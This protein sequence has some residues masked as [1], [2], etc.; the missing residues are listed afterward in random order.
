[1]GG[2]DLEYLG[3]L[4]APDFPTDEIETTHRISSRKLVIQRRREM[5]SRTR[6]EKA[7]EILDRLPVPGEHFHIISNGDFDYWNLV[8]IICELAGK[9]IIDAYFS[10][11]TMNRQCTL[12]MLDLL[13]EGR[14]ER[15]SFVTGLYFKRRESAVYA[16]LLGG[17]TKR[18]LR[19]R[20]MKNHAKVIL[21]AAPPDY[22]VMEGSANFTNN[23]RIEQ[24][25]VANDRELWE[26]HQGWI[27]DVLGAE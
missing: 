9:P 8:P 16:T 22:Y 1:M 2:D 4:F 5:I 10:T 21:L 27:E 11:W 15:A 18:G 23:P 25:I 19:I 17:L 13:D 24:N 20:S 12:E 14:I 3:S 6:R 26:H 7:A